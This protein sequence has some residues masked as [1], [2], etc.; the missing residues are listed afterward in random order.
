[1]NRINFVFFIF[2]LF[3]L[4]ILHAQQGRMP[5]V[6]TI[7]SRYD[8]NGDGRIVRRE[9]PREMWQK[10]SRADLNGD[11]AVTKEELRTAQRRFQPRGRSP[12]SSNGENGYNRRPN[13]NNRQQEPSVETIFS[14]YDR[15]GDGRIVRREMPREMWQRFSRAD[16]NGDG[17][18]TKEEL[19]SARRRFQRGRSYRL[20]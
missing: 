12:Y 9:M 19:R 18:V 2:S 20:E 16:L 4:Q 11:G 7:F 15:N 1:M 5:S 10:F 3:F 17:A 13:Y 6:E 14:R 8:R